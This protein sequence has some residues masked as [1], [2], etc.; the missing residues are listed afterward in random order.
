VRAFEMRP[1]RSSPRG[2]LLA[3]LGY[4]R[5]EKTFQLEGK[6]AAMREQ[7]VGLESEPVS[8]R[9]QSDNCLKEIGA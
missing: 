4:T 7:F 3:L 5:P 6:P 1:I 9:K 8:V 2:P